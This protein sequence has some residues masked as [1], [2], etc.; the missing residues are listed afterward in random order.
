MASLATICSKGAEPTC[1][2]AGLNCAC[3]D[4]RDHA[5]PPGPMER[6]RR[7]RPQFVDVTRLEIDPCMPSR[8]QLHSGGDQRCPGARPA[9]W[10]LPYRR[11]ALHSGTNNVTDVVASPARS[12]LLRCLL[13][14]PWHIGLRHRIT[15]PK[16]V[17]ASHSSAGSAS[18]AASG[19]AELCLAGVYR[20]V[21]QRYTN[22]CNSF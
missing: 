4:Q 13:A 20:C 14:H 22:P 2:S 21:L 15:G 7:Q 8:W 6:G 18:S 5:Q 17:V 10:C 11:F 16:R 9:R 1:V 3:L 19:A 12:N